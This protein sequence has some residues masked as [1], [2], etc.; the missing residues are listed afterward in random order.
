MTMQGSDCSA[1]GMRSGRAFWRFAMIMGAPAREPRRSA[2]RFCATSRA[3]RRVRQ[4]GRRQQS[5][6]RHCGCP[7]LPPAPETPEQLNLPVVEKAGCR[8]FPVRAPRARRRPRRAR[9][10][11]HVTGAGDDGQ[12]AA[13]RERVPRGGRRWTR[14]D[15]KGEE[16]SDSGPVGIDADWVVTGTLGADADFGRVLAGVGVSLSE[17]EGMYEQPG[18]DSGSIESNN[19]VM[20]STYARLR[21]TERVS[22]WGLTGFRNGDMTIVQD[23][24]EATDTDLSGR[25]RRRRPTSRYAWARRGCGCGC[26]RRRRR[27]GWT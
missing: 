10:R 9:L 27:A 15:F 18:V 8:R 1:R 25:G 2:C 7:A 23:A 26:S 24:R 3:G 22:A 6:R 20:V 21:L 16:A 4:R 19:L 14:G 13:A 12:R 5:L 17:G 11:G